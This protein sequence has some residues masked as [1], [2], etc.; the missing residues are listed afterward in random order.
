MPSKYK[1]KNNKTKFL[2]REISK[3]W[4]PREVSTAPKKFGIPLEDFYKNNRI[5]DEV[6]NQISKLNNTTFFPRKN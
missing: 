4:L 5:S 3:E 1:I 2:L 6:Q